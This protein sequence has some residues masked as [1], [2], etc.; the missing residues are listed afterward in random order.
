M[1]DREKVISGLQELSDYLFHDHE[2]RVCYKGDE[3]NCYER[4]RQELLKEQGTGWKPFIKRELTPDE[5]ALHP[6][7]CYILDGDTPDDE[8]EILLYR[9]WK[10][11]QGYIIELDTFMDNG[12]ECYLEG[13]QDIENGM[14]WM[15]LPEPP[16]AT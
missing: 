11:K 14:Y 5:A 15:P 13:A 4:F 9:P 7:W 1:A 12:C 10:N 8:Q 2:Y 16:E 6:E 3:A